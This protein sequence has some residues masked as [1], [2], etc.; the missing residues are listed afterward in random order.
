MMKQ[1]D[2][3]F[4]LF[5]GIIPAKSKVKVFCEVE[6]KAYEIY[7]YLFSDDGSFKQCFE[8]VEEDKIDYRTLEMCFEKVAEF[9]R[10]SSKY[11]AEKRNVV[12]ILID[13]TSEQVDIQQFDKSV[14]LYK[15]KKE[16]KSNNLV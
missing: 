1:L 13:G 12:T 11:D 16:W 5:D 10:S 4:E 7:Y 2:E 15:I 14:G 8:L 3:I 6:E 9:I